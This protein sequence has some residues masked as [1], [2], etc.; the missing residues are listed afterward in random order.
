MPIINQVFGFFQGSAIMKRAD[1]ALPENVVLCHYLKQQYVHP[2]V[3]K[4]ASAA[5]MWK[6]G[7]GYCI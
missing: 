3:Q 4:E 2:A 5:I 7:K 6:T 1:F